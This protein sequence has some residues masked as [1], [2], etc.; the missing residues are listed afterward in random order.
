MMAIL[1]VVLLYLSYRCVIVDFIERGVYKAGR[2]LWRGSGMFLLY[3][4]PVVTVNASA[5]AAF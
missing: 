3:K 5:N 2:I 4:Y 1:A